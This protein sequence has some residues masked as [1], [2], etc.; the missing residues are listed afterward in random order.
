M[1]LK[2]TEAQYREHAMEQLSQYSERWRNPLA[3]KGVNL[4]TTWRLCQCFFRIDIMT[5][6]GGMPEAKQ[7]AEVPRSLLFCRDDSCTK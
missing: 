2:L 5:G 3:Q 7:K 4:P 1:Y 6:F